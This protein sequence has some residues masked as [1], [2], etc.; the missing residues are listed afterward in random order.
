[1]SQHETIPGPGPNR[2]PHALALHPVEQMVDAAIERL[3]REQARQ[4]GDRTPL[5]RGAHAAAALPITA[6]SASRSHGSSTGGGALTVASAP[7]SGGRLRW[8]GIDVS[9]EFRAYAE[10]VARGE[11]LPPFEGNVLKEPH[12]SFPW[13]PGARRTTAPRQKKP[14]AALW[15]S[16]VVVAGLLIWSV[17]VKIEA[18][19][20][21]ALHIPDQRIP[22][23][24]SSVVTEAL[25]LTP[26]TPAHLPFTESVEAASSKAWANELAKVTPEVSP[27]SELTAAASSLAAPS[28]TTEPS[29]AA[30]PSAASDVVK[31]LAPPANA[32]APHLP[33]ATRATPALSAPP[34]AALTATAP[35]AAAP[36]TEA[37]EPATAPSGPASPSAPAAATSAAAASFPPLA[38][39]PPS[40]SAGARVEAP[41]PSD[42][43]APGPARKEPKSEASGMG[44][45]LVE[46]PSF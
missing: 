25:P 16:A 28:V 32:P 35:R 9:D 36:D 2:D 13:E 45:L 12:P 27:S 33:L 22:D 46:T 21:P 37:M 4:E 10:R 44:S 39:A 23:Q 14:H 34:A 41:A 6:A 26:G 30:L 11:D 29:L 42:S 5:A 17:S 1:M 38:S 18:S 8:K 20:A 3:A 40:A 7:S 15:G 24:P 31:P 19:R 43:A